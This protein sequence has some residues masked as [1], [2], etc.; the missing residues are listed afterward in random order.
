ML[1]LLFLLLPVAVAYGWY[2]GRR[3]IRID[4]ER[5]N[6]QRSRNYAAGI[7]FLLSEQPDKAVDLFIDLL[8]VDTDTIDTHLALGNLF[9]Q[10][11]E[12]DRAI[13]IHQ[14]LVARCLDSTEQQNLSML[15]LARDFIAAG[16]LDR[17]E[18]VLV[19]LLTD[20]ELAD[21]ARK[22][23]LQIYEQ[24]HEWQKAIDIA[25]K[26]SNRNHHKI[27]AHYYCQLAEVDISI[28][29]FK[30]ATIRL[31]RALKADPL[32]VR[33]EILFAHVYIKQQLFDVAIKHIDRIP[34]L[35]S[36]FASDAWKLL[37]ECKSSIDDRNLVNLLVRWLEKTQNTTVALALADSI[38]HEQG[39][40]EAEN[41]ILRHIKRNP[42]MKGFHRLMT[43]QLE[44]MHDSKAAES[45]TLLRSLV[46]KQMAIKPVYRCEHCGFSSKAIFWHCPSCKQWG[47]I[48]PIQGL[49]G[50]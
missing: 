38:Q 33:A 15:E 13:R 14:N 31:K 5:K 4:E 29:D 36:A 9:R 25:D 27:V 21:D 23:L 3:S 22:M 30:A 2:M 46:E 1:E 11:G 28:S 39:A 40:S 12:V 42:T 45:I 6:S 19:S 18:N 44:A 43:Y 17:A 37:L 34:E 20:D 35:S 41:F 48:S 47:S 16:L 49:D 32:C 7:N 50:D 26:L 10:R 24:L 8:Q